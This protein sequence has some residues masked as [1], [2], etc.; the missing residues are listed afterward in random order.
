MPL[1]G[2]F[3]EEQMTFIKTVDDPSDESKHSS[4]AA[5]RVVRNRS[6]GTQGDG[7]MVTLLLQ[8]AGV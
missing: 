1:M 3:S 4:A 7:E 5:G 8:R 6:R 2:R